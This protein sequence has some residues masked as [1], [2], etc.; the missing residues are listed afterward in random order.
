MSKDQQRIRRLKTALRK[1]GLD[2]IV[3]RL[4]ENILMAFGV[5]PL[6]GFSY[7][8]FTAADGPVALIAPSCEDEEMDGGWA[9]HVIWFVW[10][11]LNA[12]DPLE[13]IRAKLCSL[14]RRHQLTQG[15]I[16]YEGSFELIAP[17][18]GSGEVR[19]PAES[20]IRY[21]HS[22]LPSAKWSDATPL[23]YQQ[24]A[25][26]TTA[27]IA[28]L[29]V[30]NKVADFGLKK[31]HDSVEPG[32]SEAELAS[33]A[34]SECLNLGVGV[35]GVRHV[36]VYPQV[37]S[38]LDTY[39]AWRPAVSTG[40]RRLQE[41]EIAMLELAVCV[42]GFWADVTRVKVAGR[43]SAVQRRAFEALSAAQAA[44]TAAIRPGA[45]AERPHQA[46]IKVLTEAGF[47]KQIVHITG[48]GLGFCYHEPEPFL[49]PGNMLKLKKG[50]VCSV[51]PGV[52]DP[53]WGGIRLENNV[54]VTGDGAELL[55]HTSNKL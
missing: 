45:T 13:V 35:R 24:R 12:P 23:L 9:D 41:G 22:I 21:L 34:Y 3:L 11:R 20:S 7:G 52:Y 6:N 37:S 5:W 51:E 33:L 18:H 15:R 48:H 54:A 40:R 53:A 46:A 29:R 47:E 36:N 25:T 31:F 42:D 28:K 8:L 30:A 55:T 44:A 32:I 43:P 2:A 10:P 19:V 26:K 38:G 49:M 4:P 14:A 1:T 16:G 39:R 17:P 50:H 27:E